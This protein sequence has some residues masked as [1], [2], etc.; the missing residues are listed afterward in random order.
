MEV[1]EVMRGEIKG[2][3]VYFR[4][5]LEKTTKLKKQNCITKFYKRLK[6]SKKNS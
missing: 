4:G 1:K 5:H 3:K 2:S 6:N